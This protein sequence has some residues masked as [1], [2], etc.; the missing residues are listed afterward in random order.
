MTRPTEQPAYFCAGLA[1]GAATPLA[2]CGW[3]WASAYCVVVCCSLTVIAM[4]VEDAPLW[5]DHL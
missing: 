3:L 2:A 5:E 4:L 1:A